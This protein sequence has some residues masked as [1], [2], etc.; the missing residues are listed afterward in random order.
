[1]AQ[2]KIINFQDVRKAAQ[3]I[4][5]SS[6]SR[7]AEKQS[8]FET[9]LKEIEKVNPGLG[10]FDELA[11]MLTLPDE[12]FIIL[13]PIFLDELEKSYNNVQD[14]I[15]IAQAVNAAGQKVEDIQAMYM[16]LIET[17]DFHFGDIL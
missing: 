11:M 16:N 8:A 7:V 17:I 6:A 13:A 2:N 14:K 10:G 3:N 1:M 9:L 4:N 15:F 12:Q 5:E